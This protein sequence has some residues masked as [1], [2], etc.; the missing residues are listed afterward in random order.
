MATF[1]FQE[2]CLIIH[3][4]HLRGVKLI[5]IHR[6]L[7]ETCA[8]FMVVSSMRL[9]IIHQHPPGGHFS[10]FQVLMQKRA[11]IPWICQLWRDVFTD[12]LR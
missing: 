9:W 3:F 4:L 7:G 5:E 10:N 2:Q 12:I 6:Q 1:S 8:D 11:Q